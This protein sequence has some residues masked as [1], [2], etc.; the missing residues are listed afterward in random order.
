MPTRPR[1]ARRRPRLVAL[2]LGVFVG[3]GE[4]VALLGRNGAGK[5]TTLKA[6]MGLIEPLIARSQPWPD[7]ERKIAS[8]HASNDGRHRLMVR[9]AVSHS[10]RRTAGSISWG[11]LTV[12][13]ML[14]LSPSLDWRTV[15]AR[16]RLFKLSG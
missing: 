2:L 8:F 14:P 11:Q 7:C 12:T 3:A 5:S 4:A 6:I 16:A 15:P 10:S 9:F 13:G 1:S